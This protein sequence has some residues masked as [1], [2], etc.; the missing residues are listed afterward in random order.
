MCNALAFQHRMLCSW[1]LVAQQILSMLCMALTKL[2]CYD[3]NFLPVFHL[4]KWSNR[5]KVDAFWSHIT[6]GLAM[7]GGIPRPP[8][9]NP[10]PPNLTSI[11]EKQ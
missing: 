5:S 7:T 2:L 1:D 3:F 10:S 11:K 4:M 6:P 8:G 9:N